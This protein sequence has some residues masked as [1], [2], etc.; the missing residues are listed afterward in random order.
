MNIPLFGR[1]ALTR[2]VPEHR[3]RRGDLGVLID[4]VPGSAGGAEPGVLLEIF[5]AR[6][7]S[8]AVVALPESAIAPPP[9]NAVP[10]VRPL[11]AVG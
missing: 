7:A 5:D 10:T 9:E 1:V 11:A 4:R 8:L 3:L 2:D 6:G